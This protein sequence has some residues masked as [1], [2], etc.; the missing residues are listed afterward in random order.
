M[1]EA[2]KHEATKILRYSLYR[3]HPQ[4]GAD[5]PHTN[6]HRFR[7]KRRLWAYCGIALETRNSA[8]YCYANGELRRSKK[9]VFIRGLN[10]NHNHDLKN[11]L[12]GVATTASARPGPFRD[13]YENLLGKGMK[14]EMARLTLARKIPP[15]V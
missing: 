5:W 8:E 4:C 2:R 10:W 6:S 11:L 3:P 1:Q 13:F 14:P 7:T 9:P 12:K 15:S